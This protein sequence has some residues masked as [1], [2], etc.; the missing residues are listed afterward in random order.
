MCNMEL[1]D[2]E[3]GKCTKGKDADVLKPSSL[4]KFEP[5]KWNTRKHMRFNSCY[6]YANNMITDTFAQ[7]GML[8]IYWSIYIIYL[9]IYS[10]SSWEIG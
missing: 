9:F 5:E 10:S 6:N 4:P 7:P 8:A 1:S 3:D 2:E